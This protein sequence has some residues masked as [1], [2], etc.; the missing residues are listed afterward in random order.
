MHVGIFDVTLKILD[1]FL[2]VSLPFSYTTDCLSCVREDSKTKEKTKKKPEYRQAI[3][4]FFGF[5]LCRF[6]AFG[7][8]TLVV[9][10][11]VKVR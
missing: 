7:F 5:R 8:K 4:D 2:V 3:L 6:F 1:N 11:L 10:E 9:F